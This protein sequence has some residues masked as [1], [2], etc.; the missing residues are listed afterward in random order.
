MLSV[1]LVVPV[2]YCSCKEL[3]NCH[4]AAVTWNKYVFNGVMNEINF[5][6]TF[7]NAETLFKYLR[8]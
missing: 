6:N 2:N 3:F 1:S 4:E 5:G 8:Q 7:T